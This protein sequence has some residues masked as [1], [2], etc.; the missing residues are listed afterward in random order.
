M[1]NRLS[2]VIFRCRE[3]V[4]RLQQRPEA[5]ALLTSV[6]LWGIH[7]FVYARPAVVEDVSGLQVIMNLLFKS[8]I[9]TIVIV[10]ECARH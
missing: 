4:D 10:S 1:L 8:D 9:A 7:L 3:A 5:Y 2:F 6:S